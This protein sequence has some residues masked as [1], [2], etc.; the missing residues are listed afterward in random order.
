MRA[1]VVLAL[2]LLLSGVAGA[3][4]CEKENQYYNAVRVTAAQ[5]AN[6]FWSRTDT[7]LVTPDEGFRPSFLTV[8]NGSNA[9]VVFLYESQT[10]PAAARTVTVEP[11]DVFNIECQ[12]V[13]Y[14]RVTTMGT[15]DVILI[16]EI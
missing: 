16:A 3:D 5:G 2:V 14:V 7:D 13:I 12:E 8:F 10:D 6:Q 9:N 1:P 11:G 15:G 4:P